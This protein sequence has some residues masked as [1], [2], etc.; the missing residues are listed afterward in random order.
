MMYAVALFALMPGLD[1]VHAY[2][3]SH[4]K[5]ALTTPIRLQRDSPELLEFIEYI[6]AASAKIAQ[7]EFNARPGPSCYKCE[8][9]TRCP[10]VDALQVAD[11]I[12]SEKQLVEMMGIQYALDAKAERL[13]QSVKAYLALHEY[14]ATEIDGWKINPVFQQRHDFKPAKPKSK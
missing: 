2:F 5:D 10:A 14:P 9:V 13:K 8:Y 1:M 7:Q 11:V 12:T 6:N 3:Y 4:H